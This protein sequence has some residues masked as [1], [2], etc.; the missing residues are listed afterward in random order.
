MLE[1]SAIAPEVIS[2]RGYRTETV[3]AGLLRI[4]FSQNQLLVPTLVIPV[5][6]V[7]GEISLY[8]S[9][10]DRPRINKQGKPVKYETPFGSRMV[11]DVHPIARPALGDPSVPL[12]VTEGIKKGDALVSHSRCAVA[13]L[14]VWNWRGTNEQGGKVA[15]ADWDSIALNDRDVLLCFDSDVMLK[16][17]VHLALE[18]VGAFLQSRGAAVCY[19]Y[20]PSGEG[21]VKVGV[22]DFLATGKSVDDLFTYAARDLRRYPKTDE[23]PTGPYQATA[24]GLVWLKPTRDGPVPTP[25]CNFNARILAQLREDDGIEARLVFEMEAIL[26][27]RTVRIAV[28]TAQFATMNWSIEHLGAA[29]IVYPG[30]TTRDHTRA[31]IQVLSGE[32][33]ERRLYTHTGW[34]QVGDDWLYLHAGGAI[35]VTGRVDGVET[36]LS[37]ELS[38]YELPDPP[39]GDALAEAM[40][41]SM[42]ILDL[43][44]D[45]VTVPLWAAVWRTVLGGCDLSLHLSGPTGSGKTEL[46]ALIQQH[47]GA[48][49]DAR[50]LPASWSSTANALEALAFAAKDAI[51]VVDDFA[52]TGATT[53]VQRLHRD[54]DRLLRAQGNVS[55]RQRMRP[56]SSLRPTKP[57]RGLMISTGEDVPRGQSL[58][59]RMV[60]GELAPDDI[61]WQALTSCQ[62]DAA[63]GLY[64][65]ALAGFVCWLAAQY[66]ETHKRLGRELEELRAE[67]LSNH[68]R[69]PTNMASLAL[70]LRYALAF[71]QD[72]GA[73]CEEER[74]ALWGRCWRALLA[75]A[76][77]Q[78]VHVASSDPVRRF[79]ELLAGALASGRAHVA[80]RDGDEPEHPEA[81]GWRLRIAGTGEYQRD[82]GWPQGNRIG[83]LDGDL[84]LEPE[85]SYAAAQ[86]LGRDT[87]DPLA[88]LPR[89]L[90][91]RLA[92]RGLL[93]S[94][95]ESRGRHVVR[96]TL[97]GKRREVLHLDVGTLL[98]KTA[99]PSQSSHQEAL[100][101]ELDSGWA[102]DGTFSRDENLVVGSKAAQEKG[103]I[104]GRHESGTSAAGPSGTNGPFV[105]VETPAD[106]GDDVACID[107]AAGIPVGAKRCDD[108]E[109]RIASDASEWEEEVRE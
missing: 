47:F 75:S 61:D 91:K 90:H 11:L 105:E 38:R 12:F 79:L 80:G 4:G 40:R 89:T 95:D 45:S 85:A 37:G 78:E 68:R 81:W 59:A 56:D 62:R 60:V 53:D 15:L 26:N 65:Q 33:P 46:V 99:Q 67:L 88:I 6:G 55:G 32:P 106:K 76:D 30:Q 20:L 50:H 43:A 83:W 108:C 93:L 94:Q 44:P 57:P 77:A 87:G 98:V 102:K 36:A 18:R 10:P 109:A 29:A 66:G 19:I 23:E 101:P 16:K 74:A 5:W 1:A 22:D 54:A 34:R 82:E 42:R 103:P 63:A 84:Y 13:L 48:G 73:I 41:A 24:H 21:G 71:S 96:V 27:G 97:E 92:E 100:G 39:S 31:A 51:L 58:R 64:A 14:G 3:K 70:G 17:E 72:A 49:M 9:R 7:D 52:P 25:L 35:G 8:Q 107:C 104:P 2:A 69:T 28:T 86:A